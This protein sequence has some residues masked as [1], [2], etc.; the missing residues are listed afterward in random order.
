MARVEL[1]I[2]H[3]NSVDLVIP[4]FLDVGM[5]PFTDDNFPRFSSDHFEHTDT[6]YT[7]PG[8]HLRG[9][10]PL[11]L[12]CSFKDY[13]VGVTKG[14]HWFR[15]QHQLYDESER[16]ASFLLIPFQLLPITTHSL[17]MPRSL[18]SLQPGIRLNLYATMSTDVGLTIIKQC[19]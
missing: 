3:F 12:F 9:H 15:R 10:S 14:R 6:I 17:D 18:A 8:I 19:L 13:P 7:Y 5:G 16:G 2:L 11:S 1:N 4:K